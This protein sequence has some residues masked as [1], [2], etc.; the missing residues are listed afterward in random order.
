MPALI[1]AQS[2]PDSISVVRGE[3]HVAVL[4]ISISGL[5]EPIA[6]ALP[7]GETAV[8]KP[9]GPYWHQY[10]DN[11]NLISM[12]S[13]RE[14]DSFLA[15]KANVL[16]A[17]NQVYMFFAQVTES[18]SK[19]RYYTKIYNV[20]SKTLIHE[21]D[22]F[23]VPF[24]YKK[25]SAYQNVI[26]SKDNS[27]IAVITRCESAKEKELIQISCY[28][29]E[30]NL[31][32]SQTD[33]ELDVNDTYSNNFQ[34]DDAGNIYRLHISK[35]GGEN[36]LTLSV[37]TDDES[38]A[39]STPLDL[40]NYTFFDISF[41]VNEKH[42]AITMFY[43]NSECIAKGIVFVEYDKNRNFLHDPVFTEIP[44][45]VLLNEMCYGEAEGLFSYSFRKLIPLKNGNYAFVAEQ[46]VINDS[47]QGWVRHGCIKEK[48]KGDAS[49]VYNRGSFFVAIF[50]QK[51]D[52]LHF[53][54]VPKVQQA[55]YDTFIGS[56]IYSDG[57]SIYFLFNDNPGNTGMGS[58]TQLAYKGSKN[59]SNV[60]AIVNENGDMSRYIL[61]E[62]ATSRMSFSLQVEN[63]NSEIIYGA[64]TNGAKY[65]VGKITIK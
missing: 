10:D 64:V 62:T 17:N 59:C 13:M 57:S 3:K 14:S 27:K 60:L 63:K 8:I 25:T 19:L 2:L 46:S 42:G 47:G 18:G 16:F 4:S 1:R 50:S 54:K 21:I 12:T 30:L 38:G 58:N 44:S 49:S 36:K 53:V 7:N 65:L 61:P 20:E 43:G 33:V 51:G 29:S 45:S 26:I 40:D 31:L 55:G 32:W 5:N 41:N 35:A 9:G 56:G 11:M 52:I 37:Y 22:L 15:G 23:T 48:G 39:H 6:Y 34:I 28:D 24:V